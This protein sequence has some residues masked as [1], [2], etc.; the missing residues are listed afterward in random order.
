M[1]TA[2]RN[3][4][5]IDD[6]DLIAV[7]V[8][9]IGTVVL[10]GVVGSLVQRLAAIHDARRVEGVFEVI[11]DDLRIH[12]PWG[13]RRADDEIG[14]AAMQRLAGDSWARFDHVHIKVSRGRVKLTGYV[15]DESE[16]AEA[17]D[18]VANVAGVADVINEVEIR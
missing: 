14:A 6:P 2:L 4:A 8:D 9:G 15:R 11:A 18:A 5:R 13:P 7:S 1:R 3:D 17:A 10:R 12:P 16:S